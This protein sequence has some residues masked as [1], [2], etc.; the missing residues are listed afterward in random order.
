MCIEMLH[1]H[2]VN[3]RA[4]LSLRVWWVGVCVG[5]YRKTKTVSVSVTETAKYNAP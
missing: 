4:N 5:G 1:T 3:W 2:D